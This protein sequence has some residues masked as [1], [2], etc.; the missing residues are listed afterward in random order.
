MTQSS[1]TT[2]RSRQMLGKYRIERRIAE[3]GFA[4]VY[5]AVDTITGVRVALKIPHAHLMSADAIEEFRKEVRLT[6]RLDHPNILPIKD[7]G[8]ID[9]RFVITAPLGEQTLADR[10]QKRLSA[11]TM[12]KYTEQM[13]A[14]VAHA[15]RCGVIHCDIKPENFLIFANHQVRLAD[16]GIAKVARHTL[17]ASGSGT[18]GYVAPEQAMGKTSKASDVFSLGLVLFRMFAGRLPEWP[19][20]WPP[21]GIDRAR[22][23]L[24]PDMIRILEKTLQLDHRKRYRDGVKLQA[25]FARISKRALRKNGSRKRKSTQQA[26]GAWRTVRMREFRRRFGRTL[27]TKYH[28]HRCAGPVSEPMRACPW[29]GAQRTVHRGETRF[30]ARCPRCRRGVKSDWRFCAWCYGAAISD[31]DAMRYSD[32]RYVARCRNADCTE[33]ML[34]PF[35]RYCPWCR[36]RV[37]KKW[38]I[39][40]SAATCANCGWFATDEF[41]DHCPWC[42]RRLG[43]T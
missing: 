23:T 35:M 28:C 13:I 34:M 1:Q 15:H 5:R 18:V 27:E 32:K 12:L 6:A 11:S 40:G 14:A 31:S 16:F 30:P 4:V 8:Y 29:C 7:A 43:K 10:L 9:G 20:D 26:P 17:R 36:R 42:A 19:Y 33:K 22:K 25:A 41:W 37:Q 3:G 21:P 24:H 2:L 38:K 39:E